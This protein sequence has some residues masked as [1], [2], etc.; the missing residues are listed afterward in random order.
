MVAIPKDKDLYEKKG[1][2][3]RPSIRIN[4]KTPTTFNELSKKRIKEAIKEKKTT[5]RVKKF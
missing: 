2:I 4:E 3:Y 1:D 5:G